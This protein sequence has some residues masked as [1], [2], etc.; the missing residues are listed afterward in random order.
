MIIN[1]QIKD[2]AKSDFLCIGRRCA[3]NVRPCSVADQTMLFQDVT[4][5]GG[6]FLVLFRIEKLALFISPTD[7][8]ILLF[9]RSASK[10]PVEF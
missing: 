9:V 10:L 8:V 5:R 7:S 1:L 6:P 4:T 2:K 3:R